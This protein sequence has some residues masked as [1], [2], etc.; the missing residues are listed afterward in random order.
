M[1]RLSAKLLFLLL[2]A[3]VVAA[4]FEFSW[5]NWLRSAEARFSDLFV[6][7][8][9][10][11]IKPDPDIVVVAADE[12]S[13]E[14]LADY[15]GRWPWPR[16]VHGEMVQGIEAQKPRA[17]VF[18][19]MFFEPD[20]YRLDADELFNKAVAPYENVFFPTVRQ[21]PAGDAYGVPIAEMQAAL[22]EFLRRSR[23][24]SPSPTGSRPSGAPARAP[25]REARRRV[26]GGRSRAMSSMG[27]RRRGR[28][29]R[30]RR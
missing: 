26:T 8:Q 5:L 22:G 7:A 17:I 21:D 6:K 19:V 11:K 15:A 25:R 27:G 28:R 24:R 23:T 20:I 9:A 1:P 10:G 16:S 18:D 30:R 2:A 4:L 13:L 29:A 3:I 12:H 14:Q